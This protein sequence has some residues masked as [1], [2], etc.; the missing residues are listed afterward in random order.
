MKNLHQSTESVPTRH[1][2]TGERKCLGQC[3]LVN[4]PPP[5]GTRG[6]SGLSVKDP[7]AGNSGMGAIR[8][9]GDGRKRARTKFGKEESGA[10]I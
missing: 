8:A 3:V 5:S 4:V 2:F 1:A 6:G 9:D 7:A 10:S